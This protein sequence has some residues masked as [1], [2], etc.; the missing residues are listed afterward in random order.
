MG[1]AVRTAPLS[2]TPP[3]EPVELLLRKYVVLRITLLFSLGLVIGKRPAP[4]D[5][6]VTDG[7][8]GLRFNAD[9]GPL[10]RIT[11][12]GGCTVVL[13]SFILSSANQC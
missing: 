13:S 6:E 8:P 2:V 9:P 12:G 1:Y 3:L 10:L 5:F 4:L 7:D 11:S